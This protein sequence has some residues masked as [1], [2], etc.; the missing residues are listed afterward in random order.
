[1]RRV[2][3]TALAAVAALGACTDQPVSTS[4][5]AQP[6]AE[7]SASYGP[8]SRI[9]A[10]CAPSVL[11]PGESGSC[12]ATAYDA[13]NYVV[14]G[15]P[16][17]WSSTNPGVLT[18]GAFGGIYAVAQG[19]AWVWVSYGGVSDF[20]VVDVLAPPV[21]TTVSISPSSP[22]VYV[23]STAQL[24]ATV[25]SQ[26]GTVM[27]GASVTWSS[28]NT[29]IATVN[30]SGVVTGVAPGVTTIRA[31]SGSASGSA[32]LVSSPVVS[33]TGPEYAEDETVT[34]TLSV[35]PSGSY[36]Y[37]WYYDT[38]QISGSCPSG[39]DF[40]QAGQDLTS[41]T[42]F[43]S[44]YDAYLRYRVDIRATAGGPVLETAFWEIEG[45]A[46]PLPEEEGGC[47]RIRC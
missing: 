23:G 45:A 13:N 1:M 35:A 39:Y 19:T 40:L 47:G 3:L 16:F 25:R 18:V 2:L 10:Y 11:F 44:R 31:T 21:A 22:K 28:D 29:A 24:T 34:V 4:P 26:Y 37:T 46:E 14:Y 32:S 27:S 5:P 15:V 20:V 41:A 33:G 8:V 7:P 9:E 36:H 6:A 12:S 43:V 42:R 17:S 30:A 38:C